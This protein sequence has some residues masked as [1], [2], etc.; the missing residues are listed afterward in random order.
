MNNVQV[1]Q[2]SYEMPPRDGFTLTYFITV[3]DINRSAEFYER[4][5]G[6]RILAEATAKARQATFRSRTRGSSSTSEAG[7]PRTSRR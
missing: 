6:G 3:A 4:V 7:P 2:K 5:F 1:E